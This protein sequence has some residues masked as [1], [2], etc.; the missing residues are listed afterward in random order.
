MPSAAVRLYA[1]L[2]VLFGSLGLLLFSFHDSLPDVK[3]LSKIRI[4]AGDW[5]LPGY[6]TALEIDPPPQERP[7]GAVVIAAGADTDLKWTMLAKAKYVAYAQQRPDCP[8]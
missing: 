4:S 5:N 1:S 7:F 2:I 3:N 8:Y 6:K